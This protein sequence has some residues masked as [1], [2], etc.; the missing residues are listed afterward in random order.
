MKAVL[1]MAWCYLAHFRTFFCFFFVQGFEESF[2]VAYSFFSL[3][4]IQRMCVWMS[5]HGWVLAGMQ[6]PA[7]YYTAHRA[8][9]RN[10]SFDVAHLIVT[11][12][13][14]GLITHGKVVGGHIHTFISLKLDSK[15]CSDV[16]Q[17]APVR[18]L[19]PVTIINLIWGSLEVSHFGGFSLSY[20]FLRSHQ[21]CLDVW[22]ILIYLQ[23]GL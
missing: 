11:L 6:Q 23:M 16:L 10:K 5:P 8:W 12:I 22:V 18:K 15:T 17:A 2:W 21:W 9:N 7:T 19:L 14:V 3:E 13:W 4:F 20:S 1:G